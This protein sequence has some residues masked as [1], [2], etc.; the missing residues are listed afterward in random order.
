MSS[1]E[2]DDLLV[3]VRKSHR[4]LYAYQRRVLDIIRGV[5]EYYKADLDHWWPDYGGLELKWAKPTVFQSAS[6]HLPLSEVRFC[7]SNWKRP[8]PGRWLLEVGHVADRAFRKRGGM[9][10]SVSPTYESLVPRRLR[11][12]SFGLQP[13]SSRRGGLRIGQQYGRR[14][15]TLTN[16]RPTTLREM[17]RNLCNPGSTILVARYELSGVTTEWRHFL[18]R[19]VSSKTVET[20]M[21]FYRHIVRR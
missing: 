20:S 2:L 10:A 16:Q 17:K 18:R 12:A 9:R 6:A 15:T 1:A 11:N 19:N 5:S 14:R 3:N 13:A 4:L 8:L 21:P 7:F